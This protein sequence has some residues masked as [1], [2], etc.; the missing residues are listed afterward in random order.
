MRTIV[1]RF[2]PFK[3]FK[4]INLFGFVFVREGVKMKPYSYNHE[5]IHSAQMRE[6]LFVPFYIIYFVEW[7]YRLI[8][9]RNLQKAYRAIS[10]EREAYAN[11]SNYNYLTNRYHFAQWRK[12]E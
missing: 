3:G 2:I 10:F 6:L 8:K 12:K 9:L 4:A 11:Q 5:A 1:N 7:V